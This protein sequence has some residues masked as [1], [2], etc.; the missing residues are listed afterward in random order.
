MFIPFTSYEH[1]IISIVAR[2]SENRNNLKSRK[3][4][5]TNN[6]AFDH[7]IVLLLLNINF[8]TNY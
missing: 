2:V 4:E 3:L 6:K 7:T 1:D 5:Y 8:L